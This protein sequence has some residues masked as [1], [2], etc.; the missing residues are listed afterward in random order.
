[1]QKQWLKDWP[2][3]TVVLINVGL[4]KEKEMQPQTNPAG[5]EPARLLWE[6]LR[7]EELTLQQALAVCRRAHHLSPF[8]LYNGNTFVAIG[9]TMISDILRRLPPDKAQ[10]FRSVVGHYIA[11]TTGDEELEATL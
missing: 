6:N 10:I 1:M 11:G 8:A 2:W 4:C 7:K 5:Y 3:D 9:R